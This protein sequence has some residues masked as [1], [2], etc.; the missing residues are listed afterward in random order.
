M[1]FYFNL[2]KTY[3]ELQFQRMVG[4]ELEL[5]FWLLNVPM[6]IPSSFSIIEKKCYQSF[7][8]KD[9]TV[10]QVIFTYTVQ[11]EKRKI[12]CCQKGH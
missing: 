9:C 10:N 3:G 1:A 6:N 4:V 12:K 11:G 7:Q 5:S 8:S 2:P